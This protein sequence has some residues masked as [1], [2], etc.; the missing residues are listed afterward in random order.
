M[1]PSSR[2]GHSTRSSRPDILERCWIAAGHNHFHPLRGDQNPPK[3]SPGVD[4]LRFVIIL[5]ESPPQPQILVAPLIVKPVSR[6]RMEFGMSLGTQ[7]AGILVQGVLR[8]MR[9]RRPVRTRSGPTS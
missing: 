6:N 1:R 3:S 4:A 2:G 9:L 8:S 5:A 7:R